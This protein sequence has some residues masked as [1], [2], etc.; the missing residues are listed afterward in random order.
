MGFGE[1]VMQ[2]VDQAPD[3]GELNQNISQTNVQSQKKFSFD[4]SLI[5]STYNFPNKSLCFISVGSAP[6]LQQDQV[7][8]SPQNEIL[9]T[10]TLG[11]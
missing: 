2:Y 1:V 9:S 7:E 11:I 3:Y 6:T 8:R 10:A 5:R 4:L